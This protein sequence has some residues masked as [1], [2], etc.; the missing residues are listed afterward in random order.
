M[1][2]L[3]NLAFA[4]LAVIGASMPLAAYTGYYTPVCTWTTVW[5]PA[6]I[7]YQYVCY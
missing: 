1:L 5:T 4:A 6:V 3:R 7:Q 2:T